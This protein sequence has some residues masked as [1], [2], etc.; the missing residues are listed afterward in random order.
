ML[1]D[2]AFAARALRRSPVFTVAAALTIA[3]GI[4]A[5]TAIFSVANAV[6]FRPLPYK[7]PDRLVVLYADLRARNDIGMPISG[8]NYTDIRNGSKAAFEDMAAV[9]TGRQIIPAP[10]GT[11][12]QVRFGRVTTNFF[13][14]MG[15]T[16]LL[17]RDFDADDGI[18][19]PQLPQVAGTQAQAPQVPTMAILSYEYWQRRFG[20]DP[21]IVGKDLPGGGPRLQRVVGIL[22]P[23]F[24]LLFRPADNM[25]AT[26]DV[27]TAQRLTYDNAN[28]NGYFLR[29]IGRLKDGVSLARA[30]DEV[31][32]AAREIRKSFPLYATSRFYERVEPMHTA[33]VQEVRP[34][35]LALMGAAIFLLLI[36]CANVT[37]LLLVRGSLRRSELAVRSAL[38]AGRWRIVQ[39]MLAEAVLLT[40]LGAAIGI[41]LAWAGIRELLALAPANLPRLGA[42]AI[43][44]TVLA[45]TAAISLAAVAL[46]GLT[47]A[48][49]AFRL[50]LMSV[51][52]GS[53]R[54]AGLGRGGVLRNLV[55]V[56]EVALCFVLLIGSGLMFRSFLEL[57]RINPGYDTTNLLTFQLLGGRPGP[58]AQ[59]DANTRQIQDRLHAIPGVEN[60]TASFPFPL[61]G[62]FSTIRWGTEDALADNSKYQAVE[63][64][65]VRPG[66]FEALRIPLLDGH[67]FTDADNDPTR[68]VVV[69][70]Q[71]LAEKAF[72]H[73]SAVGKRILI[74]VRTPEP[75]FV[76][77]I[78][79]IAH[80]R[81]MSLADPGREE[82]FFADGF[83]GFA[84]RKWAV[85][86]AGDPAPYA[87]QVRA[88][89]AKIDPTLLLAD[90]ATMDT[91][92]ARAQAHTRFTLMLIAVFAIIAAVLVAVGLYGVLSTVVRQRTA[93]IGVRMALGAAPGRILGLVV[94]QGLRLSAAGIVV[95]VVAALGLTQLMT[96][97]LVGVKATDPLTFG[98]MAAVFFA[99]AA[100]SSWLPARRAAA[101]DPT[102]ALRE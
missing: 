54:T 11:P 36:A 1:R 24:Q 10:D 28:R 78:G 66:Y 84:A 19:P 71:M 69:V 29:P 91:L 42:I 9:S 47:P 56:S 82:V 50:E 22:A 59:R 16:I 21:A 45:F 98:A 92:V 3:L 53:S 65:V 12:E 30:Q 90:V 44:P 4:A 86:T 37:N 99:I 75:E 70:D 2:L 58:P 62:D 79:V 89:L 93:E 14:V 41:A 80:Q 61:A 32:S 35:I 55:V 18:P 52:R 31:E 6:L 25:E 68:N 49:G 64:Q 8:E 94:G 38:G 63:W 97:M 26:P 7:D 72:P 17:G 20:G 85:R 67:T 39:Q 100:V 46:F 77:I 51:L 13:H 23:G 60:V 81:L 48:W 5:S 15:A 57:Q 40:A 43:D 102:T 96:T 73:Q 74:R 83:I 88:E 34:A 87:A 33:L 27:W 95:G 101:L 76:Q